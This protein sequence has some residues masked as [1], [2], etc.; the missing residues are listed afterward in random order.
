MALTKV[1]GAGLG[2]IPAISGANLTNLDASDLTGTL[3]AISG[4]NLTNL[5]ATDL[6]GNLPAISGASLTGFTASQ[7][8]AGSVIQFQSSVNQ[9]P[10][11]TSFSGSAT[12]NTYYGANRASRTYSLSRT[13]TIT[14][15][16]TSSIL[17]CT[18]IVGW[19]SMTASNT[20]GH[21]SIITRNDNNSGGAL[22]DTIDNS[23]YPWYSHSNWIAAGSYYPADVVV[24]TF[25][26]SSTSQQTIKL[27][28]YLYI[29]GAGGTVSALYQSTSLFVLE[30]AG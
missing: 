1:I 29:E 18:G 30:I 3:P 6:S 7:M 19:T 12:G 24:G 28:P 17:Y 2:E 15:V 13:V 27:R 8:P 9:N 14:P 4:A 25:S 23:D 11:T 21:G 22:S 10:S 16:S 5:D 20:M 26:P